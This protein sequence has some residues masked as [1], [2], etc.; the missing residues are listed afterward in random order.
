[1]GDSIRSAGGPEVWSVAGEGWGTRLPLLLT[2][3]SEK[4]TE[5]EEPR[6]ETG[7]GEHPE[8]ANVENAT[9][10]LISHRACGVLNLL[11]ARRDA[12]K[13]QQNVYSVASPHPDLEALI[14]LHLVSGRDAT[15]SRII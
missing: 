8:R 10:R 11:N 15:A 2:T 7:E 9:L 3:G 13:T 12:R 6:R 14:E 1:L 4:D 5:E